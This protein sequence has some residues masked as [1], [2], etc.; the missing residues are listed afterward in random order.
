MARKNISPWL[1]VL[2]I[3]LVGII[4]NGLGV[5]NFSELFS[6]NPLPNPTFVGG[7]SGGGPI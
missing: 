7:S 3:L 1:I 6:T 5:F 2:L 4:L